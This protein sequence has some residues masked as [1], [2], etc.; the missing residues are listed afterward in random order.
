MAGEDT[1]SAE[2][3]APPL[4]PLSKGQLVEDLDRLEESLITGTKNMGIKRWFWGEGVCLLALWRGA[5]A[6]GAEIPDLIT[7][8]AESYAL[9]PPVLEHVNNLAPGATVAE[10]HRRSPDIACQELLEACI[11]WYEGAS[12]ATRAPNGALEHWPG[13][14]WADTVYMAGEFL[15]RAGLSLERPELVQEAVTQ[16]L[17]HAELLQDEKT[18]LFVHGTHGGVRIENFWGRA[19]AWVSLA[20]ADLLTLAPTANGIHEVKQRLEQQL[21]ALAALQ[22]EHGVWDVLVDSQV[23]VRGVLESSAAAG[24]GAAM[25]RTD[26]FLNGNAIQQ[27]SPSRLRQAGERA[28]RGALAYMDNGVLTRVSAG[29]VLQLIPFGYSVI[30]DD[31]IQP[32]GQGL[33]LEAIAAWRETTR[34]QKN[35]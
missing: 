25:L 2:L 33:A 29:T 28:V 17:V 21:N 13:G 6:R 1:T 14:V 19:N 15:L 24:I 9:A 22:P 10:L 18:G 26:A 4:S 31:R 27:S 3:S 23:E 7:A 30:R 5:S 32:W 11:R 8:F 34:E 16:W 20:A 35:A 12:E